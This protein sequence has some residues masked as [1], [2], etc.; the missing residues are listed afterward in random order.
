MFRPFP[1]QSGPSPPLPESQGF[2]ISEIPQRVYQST[3][4]EVETQVEREVP[5]AATLLFA[6]DRTV[7]AQS[8]G[9]L[10]RAKDSWTNLETVSRLRTQETK[11]RRFVRT[12]TA[13][14]ECE[15]AG[16]ACDAAA[17]M[18]GV[19]VGCDQ[20]D[21][22]REE[23]E[24]EEATKHLATRLSF[25]P[26]SL[27]FKA[28][29]A[30][31]TL[32]C[33]ASWGAVLSGRCLSS[34]EKQRFGFAFRNEWGAFCSADAAHYWRLEDPLQSQKRAGHFL[35]TSWRVAQFNEWLAHPSRRDAQVARAVGVQVTPD[36][37]ERVRKVSAL[38]D[39]HGLSVMCG[40]F[41]TDARWPASDGALLLL[42]LRRSSWS[43]YAR[44]HD[45]LDD[46][47]PAEPEGGCG[48]FA[49]D[50]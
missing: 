18:L 41:S 35:R 33:K 26:L 6:D 32:A 27:R 47:L 45:V 17:P 44:H 37:V 36:L 28:F 12:K 29:L 8:L 50:E 20:R 10:Q 5:E 3:T 14:S 48:G 25:L 7:I 39:G 42:V 15:E 34:A 31:T 13:L 38:Q 9:A 49:A 2:E 21:P 16:I 40:G 4:L 1:V 24:R 19:S 30:S 43:G 22:S 11:S 23:V 46:A